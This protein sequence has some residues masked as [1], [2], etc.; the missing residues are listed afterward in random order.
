VF[1]VADPKALDELF[2]QVLHTED[3]ALK[4]ARDSATAAGMPPIEVSAQHGRLLSLLATAI[5]AT[6]VLE[7]GT[8]AGYSTINLA[9]GVGPGGRVVTLEYEPKHAEVARENLE[10][11]GVDDRVEVI[12]GA[13]LDTL[14]QVADRS[15]TF[16]LVFI[17][18]DKENNV[19]YVEWAIKLGAPGTVIV[20]DNIARMGRVLDPAEDDHQARA[21]RDMLEMMGEHP[22]LDTAAIQTVGT[23]DWDGFAVA[24]VK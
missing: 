1:D 11:A 20:V 17:D 24:V 6:Y 18:A 3:D 16:D 7:I 8:L 14:P 2:N 19:A 9:R 12:V 13:A 23:K 10:R 5:R 4:A 22:R 21:V 15:E